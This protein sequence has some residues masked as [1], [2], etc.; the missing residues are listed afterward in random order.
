MKISVEPGK[1]VVAVSGG[2]DSVVLLHLLNELEGMDLVVAHFDHGI[3]T[4]SANDAEFVRVITDTA[5]LPFVTANGKLGAGVGEA[6]AREKRYA[7]L[8]D[9]LAATGSSAI[10]TAHHQDDVL[11]TAILNILRGTNRHGLSSLKSTETIKR[12]LLAVPKVDIVKYAQNHILEWHEDS[13]NTSTEYKRNYVRHKIL[14]RF[15]ADN[16]GQLLTYIHDT[17]HIN[18]K[19]DELVDQ[20]L[21]SMLSGLEMDRRQF[22]L[23]PH[24]V[25]REVM[26]AWL[27]SIG[28]SQINSKMIERLV[29]AAKTFSPDNQVSVTANWKLCVEKYN[30]ALKAIE[31]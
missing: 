14:P 5:G 13:T 1:Y 20:L 18:A 7:F 3:R 15:S 30:L 16:R 21:T 19:A 10:I 22:V 6:I 31:R 11:E 24:A 2:V 27:R 25:S 26:A 9:V 28:I 8:Y 17:Q 29:H 4:D 12:P 23:L